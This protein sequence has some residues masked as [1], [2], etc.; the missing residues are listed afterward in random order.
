ML[1][2]KACELSVKEKRLF[3]GRVCSEEEIIANKLATELLMPMPEFQKAL[4]GYRPP[5]FWIVNDIARLFGV[6]FIACA[7]R[8]TELPDV[9]GFVYFYEIYESRMREYDF[10]AKKGYST[11]NKLRFLT[12]PF[13]VVRKC[14]QHCLHTNATWSGEIRF[15]KDED[16][17]RIPS[18]G[19]VKTNGHQTCV[20]LLGWRYLDSPVM[21]PM[22]ANQLVAF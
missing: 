4:Q 14:L 20:T 8:I 9:L 22:Q 15:Q 13:D 2:R 18:V 5:S 16:Q 12:P 7:R 1:W 11:G 6:S 19:K 10:R 3:K 21:A 17:I